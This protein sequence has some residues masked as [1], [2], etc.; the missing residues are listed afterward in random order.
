M[1]KADALDCV[2]ELGAEYSGLRIVVIK[3]PPGP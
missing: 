2:P 1:K 3:N